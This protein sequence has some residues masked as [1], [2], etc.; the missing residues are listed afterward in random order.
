ME[1]KRTSTIWECRE[2]VYDS[3]SEQKKIRGGNKDAKHTSVPYVLRKDLLS[4]LKKTLRE[5]CPG[6]EIDF[7]PSTTWLQRQL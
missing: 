3:R 4:V 1:A 7:V 2:I 6:I 5:S